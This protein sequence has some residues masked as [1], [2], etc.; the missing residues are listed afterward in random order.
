MLG[1]ERA[2]VAEGRRA[3][4]SC[5]HLVDDARAMRVLWLARLL[6]VCLDVLL[7]ARTPPRLRAARLSPRRVAHIEAR[8]RWAALLAVARLDAHKSAVHASALDAETGSAVCIVELDLVPN[9]GSG[10]ED[11]T[12][13]VVQRFSLGR[14]P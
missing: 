9:T 4:W 2:H 14:P 12:R 6:P 1:V 8:P 13:I 7:D 10:E 3:L 5:G 11:T